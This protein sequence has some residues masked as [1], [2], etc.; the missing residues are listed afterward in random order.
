[1]QTVDFLAIVKA[2]I[3]K[4]HHHDG[5]CRRYYP[6]TVKNGK[7]PCDCRR[8]FILN[9]IESMEKESAK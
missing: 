1:M 8:Q 6:Y 5:C 2:W 9:Q 4:A 7:S 3:K